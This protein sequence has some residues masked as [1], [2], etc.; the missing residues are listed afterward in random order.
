MY[1]ILSH[2]NIAHL[3]TPN[4]ANTYCNAIPSNRNRSHNW[5]LHLRL[6]N[7]NCVDVSHSVFCVTRRD[8]NKIL[9]EKHERKRT[10]G[11]FGRGWELNFKTDLKAVGYKHR[12]C[13]H[14]LILWVSGELMGTR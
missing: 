8:T 2:V 7:R 9:V 4:P 6:S 14:L 12:D 1:H 3:F 11:R 13:I 10:V 5:S